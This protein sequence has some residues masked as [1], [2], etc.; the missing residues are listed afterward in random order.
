MSAPGPSRRLVAWAG[1]V[2]LIVYALWIGGPYPRAL[3]A[4]DAAVTTW[5]NG[6]TTPID[7]VVAHPLH[8]G[9][10]VGADGRLITV[11]NPRADT[12]ALARARRSRARARSRR[13]VDADRARPG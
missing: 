6:A 13:L 5:I 7:G 11:E 1:L 4:R 3:V 8:I 2:V 9:A 12:I 10:R